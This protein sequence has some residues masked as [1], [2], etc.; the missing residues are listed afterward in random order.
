MVIKI[1]GL[2]LNDHPRPVI[3]NSPTGQPGGNCGFFWN[4]VPVLYLWRNFSVAHWRS[5]TATLPRD[6]RTPEP[7]ST[8][9]TSTSD[10]SFT[11]PVKCPYSSREL[12]WFRWLPWCYSRHHLR[13]LWNI[14]LREYEP[15]T[16]SSVTSS[17]EFRLTNCVQYHHQ[18]LGISDLP[19]HLNFAS[20]PPPLTS[21]HDIKT[22]KPPEPCTRNIPIPRIS[23]CITINLKS[24]QAL[25]HLI[26]I[27][28][29]FIW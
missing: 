19:L 10:S 2:D 28:E 13:A 9:V 24:R 22:L 14:A 20:T 23:I 25:Y 7:T 1:P 5:T 4:D 3:A 21:S 8:S 11:L 17:H 15:A 12:A 29:S 6:F 18:N 16:N 27:A 26:K